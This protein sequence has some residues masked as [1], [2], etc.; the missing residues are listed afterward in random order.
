M[1]RITDNTVLTWLATIAATYV[2]AHAVNLHACISRWYT[3]VQ[4]WTLRNYASQDYFAAASRHPSAMV[5]QRE[6]ETTAVTTTTTPPVLEMTED[7][8]L[9]HTE[10]PHA[11]Q[12]RRAS[13]T[14][15]TRPT[16][17]FNTRLDVDDPMDIINADEA[18][19][20]EF[21]HAVQVQRQNS[22]TQRSTSRSRSTERADRQRTR[23]P[24]ECNERGWPRYQP[25]RFPPHERDNDE[26]DM[27]Y[28]SNSSNTRYGRDLRRRDPWHYS[29][30]RRGRGRY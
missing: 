22:A 11:T 20:N 19:T 30:A 9:V 7:A 25:E 18:E 5:P 6:R 16:T 29:E 1:Y 14:S 27:N 23:M 28:Y 17:T 3:N 24:P 2:T 10:T 4:L 12:A 15:R 13:S 8:L 21:L 26:E